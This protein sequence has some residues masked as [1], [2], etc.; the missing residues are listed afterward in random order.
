[1]VAA[2]WISVVILEL[3]H[4]SK[5]DFAEGLC[6]CAI[7]RVQNFLG[8]DSHPFINGWTSIG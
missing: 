2:T 1:M 6:L 5:P 4:A 7:S 8:P 3:I